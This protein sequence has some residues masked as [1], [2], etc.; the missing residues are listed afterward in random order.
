MSY[1][2][3]DALKYIDILQACITRMAN[4]SEKM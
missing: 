3:T 1:D 2:K 4:N